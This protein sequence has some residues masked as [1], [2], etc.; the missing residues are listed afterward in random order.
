MWDF[1]E[2]T[3]EKMCVIRLR[4]GPSDRT[5]GKEVLRLSD[6]EA[7]PGAVVVDVIGVLRGLPGIFL[8]S[9]R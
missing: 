7:I 5:I 6:A 9:R 8:G 2:G 1:I 3:L 4:T